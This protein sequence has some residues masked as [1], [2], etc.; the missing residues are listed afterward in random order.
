MPGA[1]ARHQRQG[2]DYFK[3]KLPPSSY[4]YSPHGQEQKDSK[5]SRDVKAVKKTIQKKDWLGKS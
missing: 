4:M 3:V 2:W 1:P 5:A